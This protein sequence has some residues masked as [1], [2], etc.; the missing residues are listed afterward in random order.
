M[1]APG[2]NGTPTGITGGK[3]LLA[4]RTRM[5]IRLGMA[6]QVA[7]L[8]PGV[9]EELND[10]LADAQEQLYFRYDALR[11]ERWWAIPL[12]TATRFYRPPNYTESTGNVATL[13]YLKISGAWIAENG[14]RAWRPWAAS[15]VLTLGTF[16]VPSVAMAFEYEVTTAGTGAAT[17]P[18]WP[19]TAGLTVVSGTVT[20]TA[21]AAAASTWLPMRQGIS[22]L[23]YTARTAGTPYVFD[24]REQ[25][26]VWPR[27]SRPVTLWLRGDFG[28]MPFAADAD[29]TTIN[30]TLVFLFALA[31]AKAQRGQPDAGNYATMAD[32]LLRSLVAGSHG[33]RRYIPRPST[34]GMKDGQWRDGAA[35]PLPVGTWRA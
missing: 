21:R 14:G 7:F 4:L 1:D 18:V 26:E 5:A 19:T 10:Y 31:N 29:R 16:V 27:P 6:S 17:E 28:L 34:A 22:P 20:Y 8:A 32:R 23:D 13:E 2:S 9:T 11:T 25:I 3:T 35:W 12:T 24:I 33:T 30:D 15:A